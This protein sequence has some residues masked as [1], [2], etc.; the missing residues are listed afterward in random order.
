MA[1]RLTDEERIVQ[2][3]TEA[4]LASARSVFRVVR[5]IMRTRDAAPK[6]GRPSGAKEPRDPRQLI[7]ST[8]VRGKTGP[9]G[10]LGTVE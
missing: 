8:Q 10:G 7:G 3:F 6:R 2:W 1:S 5:G 4:D 9:D